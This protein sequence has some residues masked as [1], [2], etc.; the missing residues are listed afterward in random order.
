MTTTI[1]TFKFTAPAQQQCVRMLTNQEAFDAVIDEIIKEMNQPTG[2]D[3]S[4][5]LYIV[6]NCYTIELSIEFSA[7]YEHDWNTFE[8]GKYDF[9]DWHTER[10]TNIEVLDCHKTYMVNGE[11]YDVD[12]TLDTDKIEKIINKIKFE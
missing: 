6:K 1:D 2:E 3:N 4:A 9:G 5:Y 8:F 7:Y 12:I 10:L 11:E